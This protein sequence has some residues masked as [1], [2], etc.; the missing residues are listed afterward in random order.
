MNPT[1]KKALEASIKA[2]ESITG[3]TLPKLLRGDIISCER[4]FENED[5]LEFLLDVTCGIDYLVQDNIGLRG[6]AVRIQFGDA[7]NT[8]TIRSERNTG[9]KTEEAKRKE[10]IEG[11]YIYPY[12]TL[13]AYFNSETSM[14]LTSIA[15]IK[16]KDLYK[17]LET[18]EN[19]FVK[20]SNNKFKTL[21][22]AHIDKKLIR[23][24]SKYDK[25]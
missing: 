11:D 2:F 6:L 5:S 25:K 7:Y 13:Q 20:H 23:T 15:V 4:Q 3:T 19:V 10:Q 8:F 9:T 24:W 17:E 14:D 22:W 16:T 18:N 1:R 21:H 12:F